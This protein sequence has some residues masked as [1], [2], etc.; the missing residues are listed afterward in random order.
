MK[1]NAV[2]LLETLGIRYELRTYKVDLEDLGAI[3]V[4]GQIG[5]PA[6]Q[7]FKT[8]CAMGDRKGILLAVAPGDC[9]LDLKALAR[10]SDNRS[11]EMVPVNQLQRLTGYLRGAVTALA[12]KKDYPVYLDQSALRHPII[13]VSS[14]AR[15]T[16]ILLTPQDYTRAT[17]ARLGEIARRRSAQPPTAPGP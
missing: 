8:L 5:L 10:L 12:C 15:G 4:A 11:V 9:E 3:G 17:A 14:G 7:V 1:T 2:R 6:S 13:S 16:Q